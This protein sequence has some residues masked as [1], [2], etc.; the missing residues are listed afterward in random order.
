MKIKLSRIQWE[1]M[2]KTAGWWNEEKSVEI[3]TM[4]CQFCGKKTEILGTRLCDRCWMIKGYFENPVNNS[5]KASV[6]K[7]TLQSDPQLVKK[8]K[9]AV[10]RG[11]I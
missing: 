9:E 6:Y 2:G 7:M 4:P 1:E 8:I 10:G 3:D 5:D 11:S